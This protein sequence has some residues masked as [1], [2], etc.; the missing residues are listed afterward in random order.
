MGSE[1]KAVASRDEDAAGPVAIMRF[2]AGSP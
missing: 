1:G 2:L